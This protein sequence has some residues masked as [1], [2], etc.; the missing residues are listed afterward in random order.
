[1]K[2]A[3]LVSY[4]KHRVAFI[5]EGFEKKDVDLEFIKEK[6]LCFFE[7]LLG[8]GKVKVD[9][10]LNDFIVTTKTDSFIITW[11]WVSSYSC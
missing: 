5:I 6:A 8:S 2:Q 10:V 1:M 11:S 4:S 3:I 7:R 9:Q